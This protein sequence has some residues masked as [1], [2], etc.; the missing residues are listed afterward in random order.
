MKSPVCP[1]CG[2]VFDDLTF[3]GSG[4]DDPKVVII[5]IQNHPPTKMLKLVC[6][7]GWSW[8]AP[9]KVDTGERS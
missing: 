3:I 7:C 4:W 6:G 5:N 1:E 9:S 8:P 2:Q